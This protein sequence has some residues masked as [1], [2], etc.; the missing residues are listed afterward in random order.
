MK[1]SRD[2]VYKKLLKIPGCCSTQATCCSAPVNPQERNYEITLFLTEFPLPSCYIF[3]SLFQSI[4][5][6]LWRNM[7]QGI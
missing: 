2:G 5:A 6:F 4:A 7:G 3:L 1:A